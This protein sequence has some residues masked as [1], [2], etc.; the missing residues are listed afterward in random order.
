M[1]RD[2]CLLSHSTSEQSH[3]S[4]VKYFPIL[5]IQRDA[6]RLGVTRKPTVCPPRHL[7]FVHLHCHTF[8]AF[9]VLPYLSRRH[10]ITSGCHSSKVPQHLGHNN[11]PRLNIIPTTSRTALLPPPQ[12]WTRQN[13]FYSIPTG[14]SKMSAPKLLQLCLPSSAD[15][16]YVLSNHAPK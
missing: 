8:M 14:T 3:S 9:K 16:P 5:H 4:L 7:H 11:S 13:H 1:G 2:L 15:I 10:T 12:T 6:P